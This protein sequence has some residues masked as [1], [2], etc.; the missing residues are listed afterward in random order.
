MS[1][2][3]A[4]ATNAQSAPIP[5]ANAEIHKTRGFVVKSPSS[6][7]RTLALTVGVLI[8]DKF[9]PLGFQYAFRRMTYLGSDASLF[10]GPR[11]FVAA[12]LCGS[13]SALIACT[14]S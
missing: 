3:N 14:S 12:P 2:N 4:S 5:I 7:Y 8:L 1:R 10:R 13:K 6:W 11:P 9:L